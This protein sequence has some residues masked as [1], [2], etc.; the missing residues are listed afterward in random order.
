MDVH[1]KDGS[2]ESHHGSFT[3]GLMSGA[4]NIDGPIKKGKTS[5]S[6]AMRRSWFDLLTVP[7]CALASTATSEKVNVQFAFTDIN[8]KIN[9]HF[10]DRSRAYVNF[11]FGDDRLNTHYKDTD[12]SY[13]DDDRNRLRWGNLLTSVGWN[14]V[15]S[16]RLFG[17]ITA[18]YTHYGSSLKRDW[19]ID[20][21]YTDGS[22]H[23]RDLY[24][25]KNSISDWIL[26]AD[27]EWRPSAAHRVSFGA[28]YTYH[29]FL[30]QR[31]EHSITKDDLSAFS[32]DSA[33]HFKAS[34][35]NAYIGDDW[36]ISPRLRAAFGAHASLFHISGK[37]HAAIS[38]RLALR[39]SLSDAVAIKGGYSRATQYIHQLTQGYISLP[40]DQWVPIT[41][42]FKPQT[43]DKVF[44]GAYWSPG[45]NYTLSVEAYHKW[46]DNL[47]DYR[48]E[49]Y[50]MPQDGSFDKYL[51]SG[52]GTSKGI[53][54]KLSKEVGRLS[55]HISYSLMWANRTFAERNHGETYPV[56]YDNRHKINLLLMW[57]INNTWEINASWT[58]Q[59]GNMYT[60]ST[61]VWTNDAFDNI[62]MQENYR[63]RGEEYPAQAKLNNYR[64]PFYHRLDLGVTR[65]TKRGYW[66]LSLYNAYNNMN[67]MSVRHGYTKDSRPVFQKFKLFPIIPSFS[68]TW[69]F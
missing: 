52:K 13:T 66:T 21:T 23:E 35:F 65:H 49:Y 10:S 27:Y 31:D 61:Q 6:F 3:L 36:S 16:P 32:S 40:T 63:Y 19:C 22:S 42:Q 55:G 37:T 43:A 24:V 68:Y 64:L 67:T 14:Y 60:L 7:I 53:D 41:G 59:S 30:P 5:Y 18:A 45:N 26:R 51:T 44:V 62:D 17:D 9:H 39:Y 11:Y 54:V 8:A 47:V 25:T 15:Y 33:Q 69:L 1:T 48:D 28:N 57:R 50:L 4:F 12:G 38:P 46:L 58:G 34:E 2:L 56:Q 20:E 29:N